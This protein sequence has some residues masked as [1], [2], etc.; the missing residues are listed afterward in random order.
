MNV[1]DQADAG[2]SAVMVKAY[3]VEHREY[4]Q[5]DSNKYVWYPMGTGLSG[6]IT[7]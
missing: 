5:R 6:G 4:S 2:R 7:L 3:K 1:S